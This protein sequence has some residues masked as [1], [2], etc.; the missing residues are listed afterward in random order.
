MAEDIRN[1]VVIG[2]GPAGWTAALYTGRAELE[3]LVFE[4]T[5]P[6]TPGG[7]LMITDVV[8]NYPGFPEGVLGPEMMEDF[9]EATAPADTRTA[10]V[11]TR[12]VVGTPVGRIL[13]VARAVDAQM[14]VMGSQGRTGASRLLLGSK[15]EQVVRL[16]EIPVL[17]A[18]T[19]AHAES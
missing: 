11:T 12:L 19:S 5:I 3:P 10:P 14:I 1:V 2:S 4:G 15:A 6:N 18:K 7:Q 9:L 16:A 13:E 17:I 8:E